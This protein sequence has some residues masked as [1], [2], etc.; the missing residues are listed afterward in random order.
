MAAG[1][2]EALQLLCLQAWIQFSEDYKKDKEMEDAVKKAE[3]ALKGHLAKNKEDAKSVLDRMH[4]QSESGLLSLVMQEWA[5]C[6][7]DIK[8]SREL[9]EAMYGGDTKI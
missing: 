9:E 2:D 1:N 5:Q 8:K 6:L 7:A 3:S 4:A